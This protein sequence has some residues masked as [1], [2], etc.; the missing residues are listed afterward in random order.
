MGIRYDQTLLANDS[1]WKSAKGGDDRKIISVTSGTVAYYRRQKDNTFG[2][3][4]KTCWW[5][6][7]CDWAG[8]R[9]EE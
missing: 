5:S 3:K 9:I 6:T 1:M 8:K 2:G 4:E 7:F